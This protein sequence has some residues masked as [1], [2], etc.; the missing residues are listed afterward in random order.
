MT[1]NKAC[2]YEPG[3]VCGEDELCGYW[4]CTGD[5]EDSTCSLACADGSTGGTRQCSCHRT[6]NGITIFT[7]CQWRETSSSTFCNAVDINLDNADSE[8]LKFDEEDEE[9]KVFD[10]FL[11]KIIEKNERMEM[12]DVIFQ[13]IFKKCEALLPGLVYQISLFT[14]F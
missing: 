1:K 2:D 9:E 10:D 12:R 7:G 11:S 3:F 6:E 14:S 4:I 5:N 8:V 13:G